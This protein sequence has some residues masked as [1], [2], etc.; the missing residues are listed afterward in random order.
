MTDFI[1]LGW[2]FT[3]GKKSYEISEEEHLFNLRLC[4]FWDCCSVLKTNHL[5]NRQHPRRPANQ[6][7]GV[8]VLRNLSQSHLYKKYPLSW[9]LA[10]G[11]KQKG[12]TVCILYSLHIELL[13]SCS[14][15]AE[16]S[17]LKLWSENYHFY[18]PR[19]QTGEKIFRNHQNKIYINQ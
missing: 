13:T 3:K 10:D 6:N 7:F 4:C 15:E 8:Y 5:R 16:A 17:F 2:E 1:W 14:V 12:L 18:E 9:R 11:I 19:L